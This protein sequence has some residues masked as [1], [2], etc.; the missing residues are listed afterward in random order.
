MSPFEH[1]ILLLSFVYALAIGH[2]LTTVARLV[3]QAGR[4]RFSWL[5]A[6]WMANALFVIMADWIGFWGLKGLKVWSVGSIFFT[7]ALAFSNY[8]QAALVCPEI[9]A[10]GVIDLAVFHRLKGRA[11]IA[12]FV[13][14]CALALAANVAYG[15][16]FG[17]LD[18]ARVNIA[19]I[20]MT[21][22]AVAALIWRGRWVQRLAPPLLLANWAYYFL[23][24]Q[25]PLR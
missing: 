11:Y 15:Q 19:V 17:V 18:W 10:E 16:V 20:P 1:I 9:P 25:G 24:F 22:I 8:L 23:A 7:F 12:A 14:S 3:G 6:F 13:A 5:W 4:V 21:L 2:L